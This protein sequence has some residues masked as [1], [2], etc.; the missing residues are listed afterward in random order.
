MKISNTDEISTKDFLKGNYDHRFVAP[1]YAKKFVIQ[2]IN[3]GWTQ[4]VSKSQLAPYQ[5]ANGKM[6]YYY[7][8]GIGDSM[9]SFP[10]FN[11]KRSRRSLWG[12]KTVLGAGGIKQKKYWH[13]GISG[14]AI[15][16]PE[17]FL[18]IKAHVL[19]SDNGIQIWDSKTRLHAA[20][21]SW[22]NNWWNPQWRDRLLAMMH[23]LANQQENFELPVGSNVSIV[24]HSR[25]FTFLSPVSYLGPKDQIPDDEEED[26]EVLD[27]DLL[28]E[29]P[30]D[31]E[32]EEY[33]EQ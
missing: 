11:Q 2:L 26:T 6:C 16:Y 17:F 9:V 32:D 3:H 20:R 25:P 19:F 31:E 28:E 8:Q 29:F 7:H 33:D 21:R 22:C 1:K 5:M 10:G 30:F 4:F 18:L 15:S 14:K 27:L 23:F 24:V 12:Y 13:Y